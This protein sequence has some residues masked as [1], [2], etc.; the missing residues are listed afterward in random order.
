MQKIHGT[1]AEN[2]IIGGNK[3][4]T[5]PVLPSGQILNQI[6]YDMD[7]LCYIGIKIDGYDYPSL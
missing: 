4:G 7:V 6:E 5:F 1:E 3:R 2:R